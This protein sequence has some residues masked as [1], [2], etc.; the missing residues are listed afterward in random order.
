LDH[1][2]AAGLPALRLAQSVT[3]AIE[4]TRFQSNLFRG[5][6]LLRAPEQPDRIPR[7]DG[8]DSMLI[9]EVRMPVAVEPHAGGIQTGDPALQLHPVHQEDREWGLVL[10]NMVEERILQIL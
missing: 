9:D 5:G 2:R 1:Q 6:H 3:A 10:P 7:D 8:R 4:P